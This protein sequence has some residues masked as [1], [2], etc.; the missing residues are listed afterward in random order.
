MSVPE[1][2]VDKGDGCEAALKI[3]DCD[4]HALD[5]LA[6]TGM[7]TRGGPLPLHCVVGSVPR[8]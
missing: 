5:F 3:F 4:V 7:Y 6:K 2:V 8:R 1:E